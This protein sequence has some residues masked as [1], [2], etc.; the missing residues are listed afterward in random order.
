MESLCS[1]PREKVQTRSRQQE[2]EP[3]HFQNYCDAR[4]YIIYDSVH[5]PVEA[6]IFI[7]AEVTVKQ[8]E[9][10][11]PPKPCPDFGGLTRKLISRNGHFS[12]GGA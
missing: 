8:W 5:A 4:T 1:M 3:D 9:M 7:R 12:Q 6:E 11:R 10:G 2:F